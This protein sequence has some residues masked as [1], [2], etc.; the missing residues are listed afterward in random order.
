MLARVLA[1]ALALAVP[2]PSEAA[3]L[4]SPYE[5]EQGA[6]RSPPPKKVVSPIGEVR[7]LSDKEARSILKDLD[8]TFTILKTSKRKGKEKGAA[9]KKG[10]ASGFLERLEAVERL[11][12]LRHSKLPAFLGRIVLRDPSAAVRA[13]AA[14]A[15][16]AQDPK[17][18]RKIVIRLLLDRDL[19]GKG[20]IQAPL[21]R[22]LTFHGA[23]ARTWTSI[24]R[25]FLDLGSPA[26]IAFF[27]SVAQRRDFDSLE[28]C[29]AHLDPPAPVNVEAADNPPASYWKKRWEAWQAFKPALKKALEALLGRSFD[30]ASEARAWIESR[31][32]IA[33]LKKKR[34]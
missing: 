10:K 19:R 28:L 27:E 12:R 16:L 5:E 20:T 32:G 29:L 18:A 13:R 3:A 25:K 9:G 7:I 11:A 30:K 2:A 8:R 21:I 22:F 1:T 14:E 6:G 4:P 24:R 34:G 33:R 15:F 23:K 31:G 17:K 26:Q